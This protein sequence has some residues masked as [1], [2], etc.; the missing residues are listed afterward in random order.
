M[1]PDS[2]LRFF[3]ELKRRRVFRGI[4]V[5]G[6]STLIL[7]EA[8]Q[9]ICNAFGVEA[10]PKWFIWLLGIGF[11][12]SLWFSWIYDVTP[13]GIIRT[14][15]STDE[16]VPIRSQKLRTYK[17]TTFL[18][19][20]IIIGLLS[21][22]IIDDVHTKKIGR[23]EKS[24]AVLPLSD[25][26]LK[27]S[28]V[29]TFEFMGHEITSCL[30]KVKDYR[31]VP[32]EDTRK[33]PRGGKSYTKMGNEL[34]AAILVDW[35]PFDT[36]TEKHLLV[37]LI[38][39]DDESLLWS[40]NYIIEGEWTGSTIC[41][42]S[43]KISK[44][45]TKK[46]KTYLT[47][48][49]RELISE[50]PVSAKASMLTSIGEAMTQ[51]TW[52]MIQTSNAVFDTVKSDYT[53]SIS[54]IEGIEYFTEA[55][56]DDST[57]A[58]AYAQRAKA[59]LWGI[60]AKHIDISE[61]GKCKEDIAIALALNPELPE[62]HVAMGFYYGYGLGEYNQ[63]LAWFKKAA[64]AKP[65]NY[66]YLFYLSRI[67]IGLGNWE[68]ARILS[69]KVF[70]SN[71]RN[72]LFFTNLGIIY[73]YLHD[74]SKAL[75]CQD[76]AIELKPEWYVPYIHKIVT[77]SSLGNI[78]GAR[79]VILEAEKKTGKE[80]HSIIAELDLYERKYTRAIENIEKAK[81][82]E[83][84]DYYDSDGDIYLLKAK[85]Y[86]HAGK[87]MQAKEYYE[88][89]VD[90]FKNLIMFDP[91]NVY[92]HSNLGVAYAGIGMN[93]EAIENGKKA[94]EL[95]K[96][97]EDVISDPFH[98]YNVIQTYAIIGENESALNLIKELLDSKSLFTPVFVKYDPDMKNLIHDPIFINP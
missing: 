88:L 47:L 14:A 44:K 12:G 42:Y 48:E 98:L 91:V 18:S 54:F 53:D 22:R 23:L 33:Y 51:D 86:K 89:A 67:H 71:P 49:E 85:I 61:L 84:R 72:T 32:W 26:N 39:V 75:E 65:D 31:V 76:K 56:L 93:Q 27:S 77:Y 63:A 97:K 94:L 34:S 17:A 38:S 13:G 28:E 6:A 1:K 45:I 60:R 81:T 59:R 16:K 55:I 87:P 36:R 8:A 83:F 41:K 66:E 11:I 70:E 30:V 68:E 25:V 24:I 69:D 4:V 15:P 3:N 19:V 52:E 20:I 43:R 74:F 58:Q 95:M 37:D 82:E 78:A 40:E 7:L 50:M 21:F 9:N 46:L 80:Y 73:L 10:V 79:T 92:A 29:L 90:Y 64:E 2:F 62:A 5:Y 35:K 57:F 96:Y